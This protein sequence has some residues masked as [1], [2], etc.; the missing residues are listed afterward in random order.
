M[1]L[2][3]VVGL[4]FR[5]AAYY[6]SRSTHT[7]TKHTMNQ[8]GK[9]KQEKQNKTKN[10][11]FPSR[12][13]Y[14]YSNYLAIHMPLNLLDCIKENSHLTLIVPQMKSCRPYNGV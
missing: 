7:Y 10:L 13:N 8:N 9:W 12:Y 1:P 6:L 3:A 11:Y 5:K 4:Y 2:P 14:T